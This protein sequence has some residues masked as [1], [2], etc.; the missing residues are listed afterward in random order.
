VPA[1]HVHAE[2]RVDLVAANPPEVVALRAE[3]HPLERRA[4]GL[5]VRS[6]ARTEERIDRAERVRFGL[7][8]VLLERV[9]DERALAAHRLPLALV[10]R[11]LLGAEALEDL[12]DLLVDLLTVLDEHLAR[13]RIDELL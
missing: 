11:D 6:L 10:D 4:G 5:H 8:R 3:E 1:R 7:G 2:P 13:L 9:L 12:D